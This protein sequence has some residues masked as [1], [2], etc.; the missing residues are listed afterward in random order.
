MKVILY[1]KK[2]MFNAMKFSINL[3]DNKENINNTIYLKTLIRTYKDLILYF[4]EMNTVFSDT[5]IY[6]HKLYMLHLS[7]N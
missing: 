5:K 2:M 1:T 4:A 7:S 6:Y 3:C